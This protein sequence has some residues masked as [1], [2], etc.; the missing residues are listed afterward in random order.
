VVFTTP[1]VRAIRERFADAYL[2]YV[3]EP[4]AAPVVTGNPHLDEVIVVS[5]SRGISGLVADVALGRRLRRA[6]FDLTIDFHGGPHAALLTW[7]SGSPVRIGYDTPGRGWMYTTRVPRPR[8]IRPRH[9]VENQWDLLAPLG[10]DAADPA[11]QPVEMATDT[12]AL[13]AV[14]LRLSAAGITPDA[15]LVVIHLSAGNPFRRWPIEAFATVMAMLVLRDA[16]R[17]VI[18]TAGPS[19]R[20]AASNAMAQARA[21]LEPAEAGRLV[22]MDELSLAELRALMDRAALFIGGD[23]G[24]LHVAATSTVPIVGLYGPTLPVRSQP[25]RSRELI[26]EAVGVEGLPCRPCDQ[27]RCIPGDFRCLTTLRPE[28]VLETA[29][30]ILQQGLR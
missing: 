19:D 3:V 21:L 14:D 10:F 28:L 4:H 30:R 23:S 22:S 12:E 9:A 8:G 25:W 7:L 13:S 1:A 27:R 16:R 26:S 29:E 6:R 17:R 5:R 11:T 2:T 20:T 24:P 18:I 15:P